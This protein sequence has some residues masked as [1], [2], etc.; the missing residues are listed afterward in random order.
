MTMT[1]FLVLSFFGVLLAEFVG[2][3]LVL[4]EFFA[5]FWAFAAVS[6]LSKLK[7]KLLPSLSLL[8]SNFEF[9]LNTT[10]TT[11]GEY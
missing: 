4:L 8:T 3:G 7:N 1:L 6:S 2:F 11:F 9:E 10:R 5:L